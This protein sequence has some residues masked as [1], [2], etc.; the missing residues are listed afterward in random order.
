MK[1]ILLLAG[2]LTIF[3]HVYAQETTTYMGVVR[4]GEGSAMPGVSV[5]VKGTIRYDHRC[6]WPVFNQRCTQCGIRF[7]VYRLQDA[8]SDRRNC[9]G[10]YRYT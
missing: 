3:V 1:R 9:H 6:R 10:T 7:H 8:G 5:T 4:D 2:M